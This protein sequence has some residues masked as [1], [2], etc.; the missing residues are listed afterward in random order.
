MANFEGYRTSRGDTSRLPDMFGALPLGAVA[1]HLPLPLP[2]SHDLLSSKGAYQIVGVTFSP[3]NLIR[4]Y[5][6]PPLPPPLLH[7]RRR[8]IQP[9]HL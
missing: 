5:Q 9:A 4:A 8:L 6:F 7:L 2:P 3:A 1:R